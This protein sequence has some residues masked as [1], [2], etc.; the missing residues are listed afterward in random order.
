[1]TLNIRSRLLV[2]GFV[3]VAAALAIEGVAAPRK[4]VKK[5]QAGSVILVDPSVGRE[6]ESAIGR[7]LDWLARNQK[8][9]GSWSDENFPALTAF[10]LMA[11][12]QSN[13]PKKRAVT[14]KAVKFIL[15]CVQEDGGIYRDLKGRKGGGLSNYNT[16][17]CMA[18]LHATR[19]PDLVPVVQKA[20]KF[21]AAS[22]HFG[23][24]LYR[25]GMGYDRDTDRSYTD[26]MNSV[27]AFESM[28]MT[29]DVEAKRPE[30]EAKVDLNWEAA[31][32]FLKRLQNEKETGKENSGGFPYRPDESKAGAT[33]NKAGTVV[34]RSYGSMTYAGLLAM[35]YS[36]VPRSDPRVKSAFEWA[37]N[38]WSLEENPGMGQQGL[39]FFYNVLT[40]SLAAYGQEEFST[41]DNI[42]VKW[43]KE[44]TAKLLASQKIDLKGGGYWLNESSR[45]WE[46]DATMVTSYSLIALQIATGL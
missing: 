5:P 43:R 40:K 19:N 21:V 35:I 45:F 14:R 3:V 17:I 20:R 1:M 18:A 38:H 28:K 22:Q 29:E 10:P 12:S 26:L 34:F 27:I 33:T 11:F 42:K 23:D 2:V 9:N 7:S 30:G 15:S 41:K 13:H 4:N 32:D 39:Y 31:R 37:T 44:L 16:S 6:V 24:D 25:G 36:D 46:A 8:K